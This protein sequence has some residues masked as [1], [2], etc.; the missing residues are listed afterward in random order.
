MLV[1]LLI[2]TS[3]SIIPNNTNYTQVYYECLKEGHIY[4]FKVSK[5]GELTD[6]KLQEEIHK[7]A[8]SIGVNPKQCK[9]K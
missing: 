6:K 5:T 2:V 7:G 4:T 8:F 9:L 3:C 1:F